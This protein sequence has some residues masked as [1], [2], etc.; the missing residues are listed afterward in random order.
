M[1]GQGIGGVEPRLRRS[2][3][4]FSALRRLPLPA[5]LRAEL[6]REYAGLDLLETQLRVTEAERDTADAQNHST[7]RQRNM[8]IQ[9][10]VSAR[11]ARQ[12]ST[13]RSLPVVS[14]IGGNWAPILA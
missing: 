2:R 8:L 5:R 3:I 12:F 11:P 9:L 7:E 1:F 6:E 4:D 13:E 14:P 10:R